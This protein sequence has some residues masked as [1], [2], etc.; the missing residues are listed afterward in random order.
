MTHQFAQH[1]DS[2]LGRLLILANAHAITG[3]YLPTQANRPTGADALPA[4]DVCRRAATQL[5]EYFAGTRDR[6]DLP[7]EPVG[8]PFQRRVWHALTGIAHG[9]T[10][11]YAALARELGMLNSARAVGAAN[12]RNP[13]SIV[14]PCHRVIGANGALTGYAGGLDAKR[15]LLDHERGGRGD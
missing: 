1:L 5:G 11:T 10:T 13:V 4:N 7:L 8:T 3:I 9:R 15:W 12:A 2:P 6:F 14:V